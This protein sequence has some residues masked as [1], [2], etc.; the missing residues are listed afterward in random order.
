MRGTFFIFFCVWIM[1]CSKAMHKLMYQIQNAHPKGN[2]GFLL[3][4]ILYSGYFHNKI[5][6]KF[7]K[8][9]ENI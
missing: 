5:I 6:I 3:C 2:T 4:D 7:I 9:K 8:V 1:L